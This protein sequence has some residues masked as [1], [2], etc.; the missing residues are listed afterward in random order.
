MGLPV[1]A[2]IPGDTWDAW[3]LDRLPHGTG[4]TAFAKTRQTLQRHLAAV[5]V[6]A[7]D[8]APSLGATARRAQPAPLAF[9]W[10]VAF[11]LLQQHRTEA[12][13]SWALRSSFAS[14][15]WATDEAWG[16]TCLDSGASADLLTLGYLAGEPRLHTKVTR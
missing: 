2:H 4:P 7:L 6:L 13:V 10:L 5:G 3:L 1:D 16:R 12:P 9:A 14:R 15:L 11:E 8:E